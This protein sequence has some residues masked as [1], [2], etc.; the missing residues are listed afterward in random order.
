MQTDKPATVLVI[1]DDAEMLASLR[2]TI[3]KRG[4]HVL[5]AHNGSEGLDLLRERGPDVVLT[6]LRM[7]AID[8]M[9]LLKAS[10]TIAPDVPVI[11]LT[12]YGSVDLAV[13]AIRAGASSFILKPLRSSTLLSALDAALERR[14]LGI[15][16]GER[17]A[18]PSLP[19]IVG[20]SKAM[21]GLADL[22][23]RVAPTTAA[24]LIE[25][26][27]GTGKELVADAIHTLSD[28]REQHLI[29]VN[30]A[31]VPETLLEAELFG[32]EKGAF[33]G[34]VSARR[35]RFE[36]ADGGTIFLDEIGC[37]SPSAQVKL[38]R[39]LQNGEMSRLGSSATLR[40]DVRVTSATNRPLEEALAR[41]EFRDDLYYRLNVVKVHLP[42]LRERAEDIPDLVAHFTRTYCDKNHKPITGITRQAMNMLERY[43]WPGNVRELENAIERAVVLARTQTLCADDLP[44]EV[45]SLPEKPN[46]LVIPIG[47]TLRDVQKRIIEETLKYTDGD[48]AAAAGLLGIA[49]RTITRRLSPDRD[50][51]RGDPTA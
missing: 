11:I 39:I 45:R 1:D 30:C 4:F 26:E 41:G 15:D 2:K 49:P 35:G 47:T 10:R 36:L 12:A 46:D 5:T 23:S 16:A 24:V 17:P 51:E 7:P 32:H 40:V 22:V 18:A 27:S 28:R 44:D 38:L 31:A 34:A 21:Q 25:G 50:D 43:P 20:T 29:K 42:A 3:S 6:D 48:K 19:H 33:T 9:S 8:G 37:L 14:C 13:E